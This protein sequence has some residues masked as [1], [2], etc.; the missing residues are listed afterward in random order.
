MK[1][2]FITNHGER[3]CTLRA[4]VNYVSLSAPSI[5]MSSKIWF[6]CLDQKINWSWI[7]GSLQKRA[8]RLLLTQWFWFRDWWKN[9]LICCLVFGLFSSRTT[10]F[11]SIDLACGQVDAWL[12]CYSGSVQGCAVRAALF[13]QAGLFLAVDD[14]S[15]GSCTAFCHC[16][17]DHRWST[18]ML[19]FFYREGVVFLF[20]LSQPDVVLG[21]TLHLYY[22]HVF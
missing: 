16:R 11:R 10:R 14:V 8:Q 21:S 7:L 19:F 17:G 20:Y 15:F 5:C 13:G 12:G 2:K 4:R 9:V 6:E 18:P 22:G 3:N 1:K